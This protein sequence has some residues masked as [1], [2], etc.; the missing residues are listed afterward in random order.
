[1][2]KTKI[3]TNCIL[4][5]LMVTL[6]T[7]SVVYGIGLIQGTVTN[8]SSNA[9]ANSD[10]VASQDGNDIAGDVTDASG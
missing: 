10:V 2:K 6:C 1:M 9:I 7:T 5:G 3:L 4:I 8:T